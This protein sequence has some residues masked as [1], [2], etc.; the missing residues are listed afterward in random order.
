M[1]INIRNW[2]LLT[3]R[4]LSYYLGFSIE[5]IPDTDHFFLKLQ[6]THEEVQKH[7]LK[8]RVA[9]DRLCNNH[10]S[11]NSILKKLVPDLDIN[12]TSAE[13]IGH[14]LGKHNLCIYRKVCLNNNNYF[15]KVYFNDSYA[16]LKNTWV[17][18]HVYPVLENYLNI[19]KLGKIITG[20]LITVAYFEFVNLT[21]LSKEELFPAF[22]TISKRMFKLTEDLEGL[23]ND[24]PHFLKDYTLQEDYEANIKGTEEI[25]KKLSGGRLTTT[26]IEE[27]VKLQP[28]KFTHGDIHDGN[29]FSDNYIIDWDSFGLFPRGFETA[30][31]FTN[32][33][34]L[35]TFK[36]L[37]ERLIKE[38]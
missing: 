16:L 34:K 2:I 7:E 35:F 21:Y 19:P 10:K 26:M 32:S 5:R 12:F 20:K 31:I 6:S 24:I 23:I 8:K 28:L 38:Y 15:E 33:F 9:K 18:E 30:A 36:Y 1:I 25:I 13:F 14:G 3:V 27:I 37:Q 22:F 29:V 17:Y 4:K 11:Y